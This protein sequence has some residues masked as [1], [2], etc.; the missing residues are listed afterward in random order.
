MPIRPSARQTDWQS[1]LLCCGSAALRLGRRVGRKVTRSELDAGHVVL[2]ECG[3]RVGRL[4]VAER[5]VE[6]APLAVRANPTDGVVAVLTCNVCP[7]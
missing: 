5:A 2:H 4:G 6:N 1:V 3:I 7:L